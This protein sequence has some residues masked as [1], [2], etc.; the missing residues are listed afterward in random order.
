MRPTE[1]QFHEMRR[2]LVESCRNPTAPAPRIVSTGCE[3]LGDARSCRCLDVVSAINGHAG[4]GFDD[5]SPPRNRFCYEVEGMRISEGTRAT[6]DRYLREPEQAWRGR[7]LYCWSDG[8]SR[9]QGKTSLAHIVTRTLYWWAR[10]HDYEIDH[11]ERYRRARV[12]D[13]PPKIIRE[14]YVPWLCRMPEFAERAFQGRG[15]FV[16]RADWFG[17]GVEPIDFWDVRGIVVIDEFGIGSVRNDE[18]ARE[19]LDQFLRQRQ[20]R[21]TIL[22][23]HVSP[24]ALKGHCTSG[25]ID[26]L[27]ESFDIVEVKGESQRL[28]DGERFRG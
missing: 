11:G 25:M 3:Q 1:Q 4:F 6:L 17:Q 13:V 23:G 14:P 20:G 10:R 27:N 21:P 12:E 22:V 28:R 26:L 16:E 24:T 9:G 19:S 2:I 18:I 15:A 8:E 7:G 5:A